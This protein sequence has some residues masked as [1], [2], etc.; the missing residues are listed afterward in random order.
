[1]VST[2][3]LVIV[4]ILT[5][6]IARKAVFNKFNRFFRKRH[7]HAKEDIEAHIQ[8]P[9]DVEGKTN[10]DD[11]HHDGK[12]DDDSNNAAIA[13]PMAP[14]DKGLCRNLFRSAGT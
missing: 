10:R 14:T 1:M 12:D 6:A 13:A 7:S 4:I 3:S 9:I 8:N 11:L 2:L 5:A